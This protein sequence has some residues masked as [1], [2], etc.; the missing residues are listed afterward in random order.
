MALASPQMQ[1]DPSTRPHRLHRG[2]QL[3]DVMGFIGTQPYEMQHTIQFCIFGM[4]SKFLEMAL[5]MSRINS[6]MLG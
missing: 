1:E 2:Y 3:T 4:K 6:Q 5:M